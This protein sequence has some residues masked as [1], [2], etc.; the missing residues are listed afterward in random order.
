MTVAF[1]NWFCCCT[2]Y[3]IQ[4]CVLASYSCS[5]SRTS[6]RMS[7]SLRKIAIAAL[8]LTWFSQTSAMSKH[9]SATCRWR[10]PRLTMPISRALWHFFEFILS[11]Q[12]KPNIFVRVRHQH[13]AISN[14]W[15]W[16]RVVAIPFWFIKNRCL[17]DCKLLDHILVAISQIFQTGLKNLFDQIFCFVVLALVHRSYPCCQQFLGSVPLLLHFSCMDLLR[18][19]CVCTRTGFIWRLLWFNVTL[20]RFAVTANDDYFIP[21]IR[22]LLFSHCLLAI[23]TLFSW[24]FLVGLNTSFYW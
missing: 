5:S 4:R 19:R 12:D 9:E 24:P 20:V 15:F 10:L 6:N 21:M 2:T 11:I 8:Y 23:I 17:K 13:A 3:P 7:I 16:C 1:V 18:P 14:D 22:F